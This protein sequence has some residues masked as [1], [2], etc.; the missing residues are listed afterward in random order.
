MP[1]ASCTVAPAFAGASAGKQGRRLHL[2]VTAFTIDSSSGELAA[3]S[4][5]PPGSARHTLM[6]AHGAGAGQGHPWIRARA[7]DLAN[8]GIRVVTFDFPY[9]TARRKVPD[10]AP[11]LLGAWR[12]VVEHVAARWTDA[13]QAI[14]G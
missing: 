13:P 5:E 4:Y 12:A 10:R 2:G 7:G 1:H 11:V 8:R 14:G 3:T 9:I 6:L